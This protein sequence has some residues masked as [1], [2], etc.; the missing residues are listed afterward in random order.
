M[1]GNW[2]VVPSSIL[3]ERQSQTK[4]EPSGLPKKTFD[5]TR[6]IR[7]LAIQM[8]VFFLGKSDD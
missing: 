3:G 6:V 7:T 5:H 2:G 1:Q 8:P 4:G